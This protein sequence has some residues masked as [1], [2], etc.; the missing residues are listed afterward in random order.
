[1]KTLNEAELKQLK[2]G[3]PSSENQP[4]GGGDVINKNTIDKCRCT[5]KDFSVVD[6]RNTVTLCTCTCI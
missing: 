1:M 3:L 6:N 4:G 5:Y 2:G